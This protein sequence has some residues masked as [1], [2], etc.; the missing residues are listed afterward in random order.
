MRQTESAEAVRSVAEERRR[1]ILTLIR[2]ELSCK[3]TKKKRLT[4]SFSTEE[5]FH[6]GS[7]GGRGFEIVVEQ[8]C[9]D[10][11]S[12]LDSTTEKKLDE[13]LL[14][15]H[16]N[17]SA[18]AGF[19]SPEVPRRRKSLNDF[20]TEKFRC[21]FSR[22]VPQLHSGLNGAQLFSAVER[23]LQGRRALKKWLMSIQKGLIPSEHIMSPEQSTAFY[24]RDLISAS[25]EER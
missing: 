6:G 12:S 24:A 25:D 14:S 11:A 22:S 4:K 18:V 21:A 15:V 9:R 8:A 19:A 7:S 16:R 3:Q 23:S 2:S 13:R 5:R 17:A 20:V 10:R 1:K